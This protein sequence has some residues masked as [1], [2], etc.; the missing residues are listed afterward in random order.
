[1]ISINRKQVDSLSRQ[2]YSKQ[3]SGK[4]DL[5]LYPIFVHSQK[6]AC[7][8]LQDFST[9]EMAHWTNYTDRWLANRIASPNTVSYKRGTILYIDL[10]AANFGHEPSFTHPCIVLDQN[11]TSILIAPCSSKKYGKGFP[12]V[13]NATVSDEFSSNTGVQTNGIRWISKNRVISVIGKTTS[14][15]LDQIDTL[16]LK[17]IPLHTKRLLSI[18]NS[19]ADL[20]KSNVDLMAENQALKDRLAKSD[21]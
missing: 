12:E 19:L 3:L 6:N 14:E 10:G 15:I 9:Y 5:L 2:L 13:V 21:N 17:S 16:L 4:D 11:K 18:Q 1:M 7:D 8:A 20:Q